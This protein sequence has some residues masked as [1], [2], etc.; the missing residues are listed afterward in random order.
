MRSTLSRFAVIA[1]AIISC[2]DH[3]HA[4][5]PRPEP[6]NR[7]VAIVDGSGSYKRRIGEAIDR[8]VALL[9]GMA[10]TK[11]HRWEANLDRVTLISL[12]AMPT[13]L[14]EG[15]IPQLKTLDHTAWAKRFQ[16]RTDYAGCTD[17]GEAFRLA[18]R[19]LE[20]DGR[21]VGKY[22]WVF[23]DL[24]DEPPTTSVQK[25]VPPKLPSLPPAN[26]PW[27]SLADVS[28]AV[29]WLPPNQALAWKRAVTEHGLETSFRLHTDSESGAV[30]IAPPPRPT[31]VLTESEQ[32]QARQEVK[33]AVAYGLTWILKAGAFV[34]GVPV[35]VILLIVL[36]AR[37]RARVRLAQRG[38]SSVSP[39]PMP[40]GA[41]PVRAVPNSQPGD[42]RA[43][44]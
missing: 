2:A 34:A 30:E 42:R 36:V 44:S 7:L 21:Y 17:V 22:L 24:I 5:D 40:P 27:D 13:V 23:S 19:A 14:W 25:C 8:I 43:A 32:A 28:V 39:R 1:A 10:E 4:L 15:T 31:V 38:Q 18:G 12:D 41:R 20:G 9:N 37:R 11:V 35:A 29:F 3:V 33:D 26:F 16:A 6:S